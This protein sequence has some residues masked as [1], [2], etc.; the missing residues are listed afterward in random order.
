MRP[1][2]LSPEARLDILQAIDFLSETSVSASVRWERLLIAEF[3]SIAAMPTLSP[4]RTDY[5]PAPFRIRVYSNH[6]ILYNPETDPVLIMR[7]LH[8][9]RDVAGT[10]FRWLGGAE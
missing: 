6:L 10:V 3:L 9:K 5:A 4:V 7:V 2:D 1:F 8:A